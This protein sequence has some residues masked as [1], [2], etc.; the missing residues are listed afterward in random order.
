MIVYHHIR[1]NAGETYNFSMARSANNQM[2]PRYIAGKIISN[3]SNDSGLYRSTLSISRVIF[4]GRNGGGTSKLST[5]KLTPLL[6][7]LRERW[8]A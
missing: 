2:S 4:S 6:L 1:T 7:D 8:K 3:T 5:T